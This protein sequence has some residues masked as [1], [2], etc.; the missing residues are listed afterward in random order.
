MV[1]LCFRVKVATPFSN[2]ISPYVPLI[3]VSLSVTVKLKSLFLSFGVELVTLLVTS[4]SPVSRVL[5]NSAFDF[6]VLIVPLSPVL[7]VTWN[8]SAEASVT[9]YPTP[10]GRPSISLLSPP[11][12][13]T[14]ALPP[15]NCTP[16]Y[17]FVIE[18]SSS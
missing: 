13:S 5:V 17:V 7:P 14:V 15:V 1:S 4:R 12:S 11:F 16:L 10:V 6:V 3:V 9:V 18:V 8:P 2:V